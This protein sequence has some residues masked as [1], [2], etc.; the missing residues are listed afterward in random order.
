MWV[1]HFFSL[2]LFHK[3]FIQGFLGVE[4]TVPELEEAA[5]PLSRPQTGRLQPPQMP[6]SSPSRPLLP[7]SPLPSIPSLPTPP[8]FPHSLPSLSPW[9]YLTTPEQLRSLLLATPTA[10]PTPAP[11][12]IFMASLSQLCQ[13][14]QT[15]ALDRALPP[16]LTGQVQYFTT[17]FLPPNFSVQ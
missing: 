6:I 13:F 9:S 15:A 12:M 11:L 17:C 2:P 4:G 5:T 8:S 3:A 14:W 10:T 1:Q 16:P 7:S